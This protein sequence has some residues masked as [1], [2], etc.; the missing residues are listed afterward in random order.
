MPQLDGTWVLLAHAASTLYLVGLIWLVQAVHYPLFAQVGAAQAQA[1]A[2][3]HVT[4]I[5]WVVGPPMLVELASGVWLAL[6]PPR[7]LSAGPLWVGLLL[8]ALIWLST[9]LL[10]VP[11]HRRLEVGPDPAAVRRLVRGNWLRTGLWTAR[12]A[13]V[14]FLLQ[15]LLRC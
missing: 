15:R 6:S 13:L 4:R 2:R 7:G 5:T 11:E 1:Y 10:Q 9:A 12:G 3:L 14:L 8:L